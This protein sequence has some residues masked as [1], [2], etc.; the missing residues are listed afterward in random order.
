MHCD[1]SVFSDLILWRVKLGIPLFNAGLNQPVSNCTEY[2][3]ALFSLEIHEPK[4]FSNYKA[5]LSPSSLRI[6]SAKTFQGD[7]EVPDD[8]PSDYLP[9]HDDVRGH[10]DDVIPH[11]RTRRHAR[12]LKQYIWH[13]KVIPY[14]IHESLGKVH[15]RS[16][17]WICFGFFP[18]MFD[19]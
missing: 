12:R 19:P 11:H 8:A 18:K 6:V 15:S 9:S 14:S 7:I 17:V 10:N 5:S 13:A 1:V 16:Q 2:K 3:K 4:S